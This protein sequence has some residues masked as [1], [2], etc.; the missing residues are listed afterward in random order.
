M[1][2]EGEESWLSA[3][4]SCESGGHEASQPGC[5]A[6]SAGRGGGVHGSWFC[7]VSPDFVG[8]G[9]AMLLGE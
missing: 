8:Q 6:H 7:A 1:G 2:E 4:D 5:S 3:K 9:L